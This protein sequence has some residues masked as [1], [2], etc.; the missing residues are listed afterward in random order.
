MRFE[1]GVF[2]SLSSQDSSLALKLRIES[3]IIMKLHR[4][5]WVYVSRKHLPERIGEWCS[6]FQA[7]YDSDS[8]CIV[9]LLASLT[10]PIGV[11]R[12]KQYSLMQ[13]NEEGVRPPCRL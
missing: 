13:D 10:N 8:D 2:R 5:G 4:F 11:G 12:R 9:V 6:V 1:T 3:I 7:R